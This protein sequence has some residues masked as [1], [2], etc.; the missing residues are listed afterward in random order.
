MNVIPRIDIN[1]RSLNQRTGNS[2]NTVTKFYAIGASPS[3]ATR[4]TNDFHINHHRTLKPKPAI[5]HQSPV[6]ILQQ[7]THNFKTITQ[8]LRL[9]IDRT[10]FLITSNTN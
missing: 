9:L 1:R 2:V 10:A 3:H 5:T 6:P 7:Q 4:S 8:V